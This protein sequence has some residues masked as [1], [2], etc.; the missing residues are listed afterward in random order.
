MRATCPIVL[1]KTRMKISHV[2][3]GIASASAGPS[4]SVGALAEG[5]AARRSN[6]VEIVTLGKRPDWWCYKVTVSAYDSPSVKYGLASFDYLRYLRTIARRSAI[7]HGH[8]VWRIANLFPLVIPS[9]STVRVVISP[10]GM[11]SEWSWRHHAF[12]KR[13]VWYAL[14]LPAL[15]RTHCFH[16]TA[17][18]ELEDIRR[19]GFRQPVT[20]IPNGITVPDLPQEIAKENTIVFLSRIHKKK[21]LEL[22]IEA[23]RRIAAEHPLW[24][25]KIAGA[26]D[27]DYAK[28][29]V[30]NVQR[31]MVPRVQF[32]GEVLGAEKKA[33]LSQANL[34]V[35]PSY[36]ENFGIAVAEALAH[37]TAVITT[38]QTP[39]QELNGK[40]CGWCVAADQRSIDEALRD[41]LSRT[42]ASLREMG[43][44]GREW[45]RRDFSWEAVTDMMQDT[46]SW[47]QGAGDR[48]AC[49]IQ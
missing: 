3:Q 38:D 34:F 22:L 5:L 16:A 13:P 18:S 33:L 2:I 12:V 10:R 24:T 20:V 43:L 26:I 29:L 25:L 27:S 41:A 47:L 49:V 23:W 1:L 35:L 11:F 9:D 15:Q 17:E 6:D 32:L 48:P 46:Y 31:E 39:W 7:L 36:S 30:S 40:G 44:I 8:G 28:K 37:G 42:P 19:L 4:H 14:Q 21:G 45:M